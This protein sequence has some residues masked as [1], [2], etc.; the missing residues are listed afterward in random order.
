[1]LWLVVCDAVQ[2]GCGEVLRRVDFQDVL[3]RSAQVKLRGVRTICRSI[4]CTL[5]CNETLHQYA[6]VGPEQLR[7]FAAE[8]ARPQPG[9]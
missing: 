8:C 5:L 2:D 3:R 4:M 7:A 1:M 9:G 6:N